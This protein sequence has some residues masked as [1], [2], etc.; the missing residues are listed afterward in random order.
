MYLLPVLPVALLVDVDATCVFD[1]AVK[2]KFSFMPTHDMIERM[3]E[4]F[5]A[6]LTCGQNNIAIIGLWQYR[7]FIEMLKFVYCLQQTWECVYFNG[8]Y[9]QA[10]QLVLATNAPIQ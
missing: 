10:L 5:A 6:R 7:F 4:T 2:H 1:P 3:S 9:Y 8:C